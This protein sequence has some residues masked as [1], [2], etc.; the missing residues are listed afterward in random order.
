MTKLDF[1]TSRRFWAL[2]LIGVVQV[3]ESEAIIGGEIAGALI[4]ILGGFIGLT[5]VQKF[6]K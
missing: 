6:V 1:L 4:T 5:T 3:L 2:V